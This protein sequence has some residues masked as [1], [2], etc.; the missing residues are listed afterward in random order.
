[1]VSRLIFASSGHTRIE[2]YDCV[3]KPNTRSEWEGRAGHGVTEYAVVEE[4]V[5]RIGASGREELLGPNDAIAFRHETTN[6]YESL[7][8]PARVL[9]V[10][11]Y[12]GRTDA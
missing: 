4:G 11:A 1:M 6:A 10:I 12:D 7:E 5:V 2:I 3:M 9:C 8:T